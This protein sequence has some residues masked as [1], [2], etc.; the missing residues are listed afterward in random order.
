[1]ILHT[2]FIVVL[3]Q[4]WDRLPPGNTPLILGSQNGHLD[5]VKYLVGMKANIEAK[6]NEGQT[7]LSWAIKEGHE[8]IVDFLRNDEEIQKTRDE[9]EK[10]ARQKAEKVVRRSKESEKK[11]RQ[12]AEEVNSIFK[13]ASNN[14][15]PHLRLLIEQKANV[16][17][18][19]NES[20]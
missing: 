8:D 6:N 15:L 2:N 18:K 9:V 5:T 17:T 12:E 4:L 7:A 20:G 11:A 10:Q 3:C 14:D 16:E 13:A 1:L 19:N